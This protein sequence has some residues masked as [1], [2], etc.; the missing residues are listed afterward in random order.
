MNQICCVPA[1]ERFIIT[2]DEPFGRSRAP[3]SEQWGAVCS[4]EAV[5]E[6][7]SPEQ[8]VVDSFSGTFATV[9]TCKLLPK[10]CRSV[11]CEISIVLSQ[12]IFTCC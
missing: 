3:R 9:I 8:I 11:E 6:F 2:D 5:P 10:H 4:Q 1:K 7:M 12:A